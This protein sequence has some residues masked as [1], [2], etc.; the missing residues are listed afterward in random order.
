M[1]E[2]D[3]DENGIKKWKKKLRMNIS[4]CINGKHIFRLCLFYINKG[5][6]VLPD[7]NY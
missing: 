7:R 6:K 2:A 4:Q 3:W 1:H 5:A